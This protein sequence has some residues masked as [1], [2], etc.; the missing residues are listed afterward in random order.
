MTCIIKDYDKFIHKYFLKKHC[1]LSNR[2]KKEKGIAFYQMV[3]L[4]K[5]NIKLQVLFQPKWL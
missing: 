4:M 5:S 2:S 1:L 3:E